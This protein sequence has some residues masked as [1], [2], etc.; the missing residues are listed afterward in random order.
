M[1]STITRVAACTTLYL[2]VAFLAGT[3]NSVTD[4]A[5]SPGYS[6]LGHMYAEPEYCN[7][8]CK[9]CGDWQ[10]QVDPIKI[11]YLP[12]AYTNHVEDCQPGSCS[13]HACDLWQFAGGLREAWNSIVD[14]DP[15]QI[16]QLIA[17]SGGAIIYNAARQSIQF[18]CE[19]GN[20]IGNMPISAA[21]AVAMNELTAGTSRVFANVE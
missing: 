1:L 19:R 21:D 9:S 12:N 14:A 7:H 16:Q 11:P 13:S 4:L 6:A 18:V 2:F 3:S 20:L 15:E 8:M 5:A 17:K 10:H